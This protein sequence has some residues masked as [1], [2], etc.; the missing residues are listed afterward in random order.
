MKKYD[1]IAVAALEVVDGVVDTTSFTSDVSKNINRM[2]ESGLIVEVQYSTNIS[3]SG[4]L[5]LTALLLGYS[6]LRGITYES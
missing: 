6:P 5:I 3:K 2:Q 1:A 4:N